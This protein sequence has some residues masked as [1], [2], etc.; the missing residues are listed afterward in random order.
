M[1]AYDTIDRFRLDGQVSI[2][3]GASRGLGR[4]LA[5]ALAGAGADVVLT[6]RQLDTLTAVADPIRE[7]TGR[8]VLPL[9]LDQANL[10]ELQPAVDRIMAEFGRIDVLVNNAGINQRMPALEFTEEAWDAVLDVNLKGAFFLTQAVGKVMTARQR[11]KIIN[12]LSLTTAWGLPTVV[13]YTAAKA[14]L[15][16][17]TKLLAVEW[18]EQNV[19]VNGIAPGFFRTEMTRPV[20]NDER[21][22]WIVNRTPQRRWGEPEELTG[23]ALFLASGASNFVTGQVLWVDGG[24]TAGSDWRRGQ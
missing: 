10:A 7:K 22:A 16:Q 20:Q 4:A 14:G 21:S 11:G 13:A 2:V 15:M 1:P 24:M 23:A 18:A 6:G 12:I 3:T 8:K 19:Q 9:V 5:E 17:L